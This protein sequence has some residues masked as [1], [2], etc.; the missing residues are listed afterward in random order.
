MSDSFTEGVQRVLAQAA[1]IAHADAADHVHARHLLWSLVLDETVATRILVEHNVDSTRL[2]SRLPVTR[3]V[4]ANTEVSASPKGDSDEVQRVLDRARFAARKSDELQVTTQHLLFALVSVPSEVSPIFAE[5]GLE[6]SSIAELIFE[7]EAEPLEVDI[8]WDEA[9]GIEATQPTQGQSEFDAVLRVLDAAWNRLREGLRVVED[10]VRFILDNAPLTRELKSIRHELTSAVTRGLDC[11]R[12]LRSRDTTHDVGTSIST[13]AEFTRTGVA[14]VVRANLSRV[15]ESLRTLEEFSKTLNTDLARTFE[16]VRYRVYE[17]ER[18]LLLDTDTA[19]VARP[20]LD[21]RPLYLLVTTALCRQPIEAVVRD[22]IEGGV[23]IVQLRE[24]L[25]PDPEIVKLGRTIREITRESGAVFIMNDRPDLAVLTEA[26]GVHVGQDE[27]SV[28]DARRIVG[29]NCLVGV[30][31]HSIAQARKAVDDGADYIGVGPVFESGTKAFDEFAGL[32]FVREVAVKID[33]PWFAI[34]GI[35]SERVGE[36][37]NAGGHCV[38]VSGAI[39]RAEQPR[40]AARAIRQ[41][42]VRD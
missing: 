13:T 10:Y 21:E 2:E 24:K 28:A 7:P 31:T 16:A 6:A 5:A 18:S 3:S 9:S 27:L 15:Q 40:E 25:M 12:L 30:S 34:G 23:S 20:G 33:I 42:L 4:T 39:C 37:I 32:E 22:A 19:L 35:D 41:K 11:E 26:D 17:F 36:V 38:A 14:D 1:K 8:D 29:T